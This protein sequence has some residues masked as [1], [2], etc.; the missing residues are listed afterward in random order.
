[1]PIDNRNDIAYTGRSPTLAEVLSVQG[2]RI[3][4]PLRQWV[5]IT[6]NHDYMA[7]NRELV[8]E[9]IADPDELVEGESGETLALRAYE[10]TNLTAKTVIVVYRDE[11]NGFVI[12]AWLTSRPDRASERSTD[13]DAITIDPRLIPLLLTLPS[14][15]FCVDYDEEG[16]VLYLSFEKPQ[17]ATDSIMKEDGNVYHYRGERLVGV[18]ILHASSRGQQARNE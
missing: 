2:H 15:Q 1:M 11:P 8:L 5:H 14:H 9:G 7:G 4:L 6:E 3:R 10:R 13:M 16:D 18:T 17:Q 12:T